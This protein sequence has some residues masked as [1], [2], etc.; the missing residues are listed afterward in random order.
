MKYFYDTEFY[1]DGKTIDL[2][3]IG[4]VAEDGR[5]F[6]A[7]SLDANLDVVSVW[8]MDHVVK[9]LWSKQKDKSE[10]NDWSRDGGKGGLLTRA[11]INREIQLFCHDKPE[12]WGYYSAYDHVVLAQLFGAMINF[13]EGWP[14]YTKD[15]KQF[16]DSLG[17]PK[18]PEDDGSHHAL[19]D[20]RWNKNAYKFLVDYKN[21]RVP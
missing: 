18:L 1:E 6:Y 13:P 7:E 11:E 15:I 12:F 4:I 16:C 14:F 2:I 10:F 20:A 17:N 3:S 9:N 19:H 8:V 5:E 21:I